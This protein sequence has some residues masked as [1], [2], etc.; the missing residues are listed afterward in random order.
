MW[1][2]KIFVAKLDI[3]AEGV[4]V[5]LGSS[6]YWPRALREQVKGKGRGIDWN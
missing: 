5:L 4:V 3:L 1:P 6:H 2:V